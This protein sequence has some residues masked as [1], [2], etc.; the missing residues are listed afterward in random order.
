MSLVDYQRKRSFDR[1]REPEP[2]KP[3]PRGQRPIFVVQLH[4]A[5][6]RH[7]DFR[8]QVGDALKSWAVPKGPSYDPAVK[9][10]AVEVEDHPLDYAGFE[11]EI[12]RGE[13]GGGHVAR[14][15]HG[16]WST[17]GDPEEQL[18]KGHLRFELHG[19][20]LKGGWHLVRSGKPARQPQWLLFKDKDAWAGSLEADDLLAEVTPAPEEDRRRAGRGKP[21]RK[22]LAEVPAPRARHKDWKKRALALPGARAAEA[23]EGPFQPQ[24]A[25]LGQDAP[26]GEQWL[27][28]IKW[29]G[30]RILATVRDGEVRL[31]SRNALEWTDRIPEIR[32]AVKALGLRSAALDGELIAGSGTREDFNLLQ[33]TLS[34]ERPGVL[35]Y[36]LFDLLH[37]DGV[38]ISEAPL[39]ERKQLLQEVLAK[40]PAHLALS[41]HIPGDGAQA[42]A[43]AAERSFEGIISKRADRPYRPGRG[44]DWR[45]TKQLA[46]DE[47]A[48]VG[49]TAPQGSR[50]GFGS[51][52]LARPDAKHG[53]LYVGRVGTGFSD[54]LLRE[55]A[56]RLAR[57][58]GSKPTAHV[59]TMDTAL[60]RAT[61][62]PPRL[63][64]EVFYR[65]IGGQQLL[66]QAS[67]K[68]LRP[69]KS[70]DDLYDSDRGADVAEEAAMAAKGK[71][72]GKAM[73]KPAAKKAPARKAAT[74]KAARKTAT[75]KA[76]ARKT[77]A[78]RK[79]GGATTE[80]AKTVAETPA[81]SPATKKAK[82]PAKKA[83]QVAAAKATAAT[84]TRAGTSRARL[85]GDAPRPGPTPHDWPTLSSP[86]KILFPDIRATKQDVWDYYAAVMD[87]LLPEIAGRPLSVIRCPSGTGKPCFF[88]K[89]LTA[90]LERVA[91]VKLKEE[92]GTNAHYLVV[93]D[94]AG[95][96]ELVQFNALEFHP[97]G[98]HADNPDSADRVVF[99]LD[100][101]P[102]VPFSEVKKAAV[103]IR[104][105]LE[106]LEL[107]S[108]L[109]VTGGKGLH[110]V[111]PLAPGCDWELTKRF[112]HGFAD[113]L[114]RSEPDRF[115]ATA[116]KRFR[117]RRI[118]VDY[119]RNGRGATAVASYSLRARPGAPVAMPIG[120][121]EL[122]RLPRADLYTIK[123]VPEKLRRR[124]KD[125]WAGMDAIRQNLARWADAK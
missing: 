95:L 125:P 119:L 4:H 86:T 40:G 118:F 123:D 16:V 72:G 24:L 105:Q 32:D 14:F 52:L 36:V 67:L 42:A 21:T 56:P 30:Y 79:A 58:T 20:K 61:W 22:R 75:T 107:E 59:A 69:D 106:A 29:D 64:V 121:N 17:E 12:P 49:Y 65:G 19:S 84:A 76:G 1:T 6:R 117:N 100:P 54:E 99:D 124:R 13:Y 26:E 3:A 88:Q 109:R 92:S 93:E 15:D 81:R 38:D 50:T 51:L 28:E 116:T 35:A 87:H 73:K 120:W 122:A 103:D 8:L 102:D 71:G 53:W 10:M 90:G 60:R 70:I 113:A 48:I 43:L 23:P 44:D 101:G 2:G 46:S 11:G 83:K 45:K 47:F 34:G 77:P 98:S 112:A 104:R 115:V 9:R 33:A 96:M 25:R 85:A 55:L 18:A 78:R 110:V 94:A 41:S 31:W 5:S 80:A 27:H 97:W 114:A 37:V 111:V 74:K 39:L 57:D 66:R 91:S 68:A 7:Y 63:V 108:F 62:V 89:H 82:S